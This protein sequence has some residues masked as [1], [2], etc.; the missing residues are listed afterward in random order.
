M[1]LAPP[2]E[3][4][5]AFF[6]SNDRIAVKIGSPLFKF[7]EVFDRLQCPLGPKQPLNIHTTKTRGIKTM[8]KFLWPDIPHKVRRGVCMSVC[9]A[10]KTNDPTAWTLGSPVL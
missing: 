5:D 3:D 8:P 9:M 4:I 10:V 6:R 2:F 1:D 7:R